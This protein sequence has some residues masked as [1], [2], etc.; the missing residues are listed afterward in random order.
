MGMTVPY[1]L[2]QIRNFL[3]A[4]FILFTYVAVCY[5]TCS[6][7]V[8]LKAKILSYSEKRVWTEKTI[9]QVKKKAK[10]RPT[11]SCLILAVVC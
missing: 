5:M 3:F 10:R 1:N 7:F 6:I 11:R 2:Q 9:N 4:F 8:Y